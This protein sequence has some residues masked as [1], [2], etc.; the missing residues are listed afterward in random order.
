M[1]V[2]FVDQLCVQVFTIMSHIEKMLTNIIQQ[3][4]RTTDN[5][6]LLRRHIQGHS[7]S[8]L[9]QSKTYIHDFLL[10]INWDLSFISHC[11]Q[12]MVPQ[13]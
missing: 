1:Q 6:Q 7:R 13:S 5:S 10:V 3:E 9:I 12:D 2:M 4:V 11:L 8:F